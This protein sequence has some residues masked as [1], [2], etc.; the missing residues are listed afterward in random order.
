[1]EAFSRRLLLLSN[2][3]ESGPKVNKDLIFSLYFASAAEDVKKLRAKAEAS[4]FFSHSAE[5]H[6]DYD[7][8]RGRTLSRINLLYDKQ[9]RT[10]EDD[11]KFPLNKLSMM[12]VFS[13]YDK[14]TTTRIL[15]HNILFIDSLQFL[16]SQ[17]HLPAI[18]RAYSLDDYGCFAMTELGHGSNVLALETTATYVHSDRQFEIN[19]PTPTSA[20]WWIGAAGKTAN[21]A[22]LFA[23][24][25]VRGENKGVHAFYIHI[26]DS[27]HLTLP[28]VTVGDCGPKIALNGIDNGFLIFHKYRVGYESLLDRFS[29]ITLDGKFR[30]SIKNPEKRFATMLAGL[31]RG[32]LSVVSSAEISLRTSLTITYR[33]LT[34]THVEREE[35]K[36]RLIDLQ[37][38]YLK[39]TQIL[40]C[41]LAIRSGLLFLLHIYCKNLKIFSENPDGEELSE[42]HMMI[43]TL[44]PAASWISAQAHEE[45]QDICGIFGN[46]LQASISRIKSNQDINVTWEGDNSV[47][48]QQVG[49]YIF[50]QLKN[51]FKGISIK[52]LLLS[53]ALMSHS[54]FEAFSLK[55]IKIFEIPDLFNCLK[56]RFNYFVFKSLEKL[57]ENAGNSESITEAWN[58]TQVFHIQELGKSFGDYLLMKTFQDFCLDFKGKCKETFEVLLKFLQVFI[59]S[60]I[61][62]GSLEL[63]LSCLTTAQVSSLREKLLRLCFELKE[64]GMDVINALAPPDKLLFSDIGESSGN[65]FDRV[66]E[67]TAGLPENSHL[68]LG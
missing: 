55:H 14:A 21:V 2:H 36:G 11:L 27:N 30:S 24:M 5:L 49:K 35:F 16:G 44:K 23:Q 6:A 18:R 47:L 8:V 38:N 66:F 53:E 4:D 60:R 1:M 13:E 19:S 43:S 54:N 25:V 65:I 51:T 63:L 9:S 32:R 20:K 56:F 45:M 59:I 10:L 62:Q 68:K 57:Q 64:V 34:G 52:S 17:K 61:V 31:I 22:V 26:R 7:L 50:K 39:V 37:D 58:K 29:E 33:F 15:V 48:I 3:L 28:G 67:R 46:Y 41:M 12:Y 40:S 42:F